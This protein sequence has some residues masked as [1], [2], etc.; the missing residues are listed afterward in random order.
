MNDSLARENRHL[1]SRLRQFEEHRNRPILRDLELSLQ[2]L[3]SLAAYGRTFEDLPRPRRGGY[4]SGHRGD[5]MAAGQLL[6]WERHLKEINRQI[7]GWLESRHEKHL[8]AD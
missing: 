3:E 2:G 1:K 4:R 5:H 8:T 6:R 7:T